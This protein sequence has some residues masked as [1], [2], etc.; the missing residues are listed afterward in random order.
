V[1]TLAS[2]PFVVTTGGLIITGNGD[3]RFTD[4]KRLLHHQYPR[5]WPLCSLEW[6]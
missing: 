3:M 1:S 5:S 2:P 4:E 6:R